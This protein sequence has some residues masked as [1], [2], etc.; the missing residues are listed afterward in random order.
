MRRLAL[1]LIAG[2]AHPPVARPAAPPVVAV[3]VVPAASPWAAVPVRV[4]TWTARGVEPIGALPGALPQP[5]PAR[6]YVEPIGK[7]D[8]PRFEQLVGLVRR[9]H[10]PGL[11]LRGQ[12]VAPWLA[13]LR[14]LPAL[15]ALLLD[16]TAT[17]GAA[18]ASVQLAVTRLYLAHTAIDDD[19]VVSLVARY[20]A[21]EVLDVEDTAVGDAGARAIATLHGLHAVNLAGTQLTDDG[22]AALA[23]LAQLEIADLGSTKVGG[24][25]IAA[26][27]TLPLHELFLDHTRVRGELATLAA[28]APGL[29]RFDISGTAHHPSDAELAWLAAAPNLIEL[30]L[31][32]AKLHD[33]L[34][35]TLIKPASLR[36]VRLADTE[37]TLTTI[38]VLAARTMLEEVDLA[39]TAVDDPSAAALLALPHMRIVRLDGTP[40]TNAAT[41]AAPSQALVE[42][43]VSRTALDDRGLEL[44]DHTPR[45]V[46]LGVGHTKLGD[47]TID[48]IARLAALRTLVL[49]NTHA[50]PEALARLGALHALERLYLDQ[51]TVND[52]VLAALAPAASTLRVL[53]LAA[54]SVSDDGLPALRAFTELAELTAGDTGMKAGIADLTAWPRLRTLSLTGL[55]LTDQVLPLLAA[56]P[57]LAVLDLSATDIHD[58]S[59]LAALPHLRTLGLA[60]TKLSATGV[61]ASKRLAAR[62]V[63]IVR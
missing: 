29:V 6:W 42:L 34:A 23:T 41:A 28:L 12:P 43:Y 39:G 33:P 25:T 59:P 50:Q 7:L 38:R 57:S 37:I 53:H 10:V 60:Q 21:L 45:L 27:R 13:E 20:P 22:G 24:K 49:S 16:D 18:L 15:A 2:C 58:P 35:L 44:L 56:R 14:D 40:I 17:D 54:S 1:V 62:G 5:M 52:A 4:M 8:Q 63:E 47:A 32:G 9:E 61:A 55:E 51:T 36:E 3:A 31:D 11:S 46:A 26:L 30:G 19:A 48:R